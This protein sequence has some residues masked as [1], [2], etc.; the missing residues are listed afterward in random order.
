MHATSNIVLPEKE[1]AWEFNRRKNTEENHRVSHTKV[2]QGTCWQLEK[3]C[4]KLF[5]HNID[6]TL[7]TSIH[8]QTALP[9][10]RSNVMTKSKTMN[11]VLE[12]TSHLLLLWADLSLVSFL[13]SG[14]GCL[15]LWYDGRAT[16][17]AL[18]LYSFICTLKFQNKVRT[19]IRV[20]SFSHWQSGDSH[21]KHMYRSLRSRVT[22]WRFCSVAGLAALWCES[23]SAH[24]FYRSQHTGPHFH[25]PVRD[26]SGNVH[27]RVHILF[28]DELFYSKLWRA[29]SL[30]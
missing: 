24:T 21:Q 26:S 13:H 2:S 20:A 25:L 17:G 27:S 4:R 30:S 1:R 19:D 5:N 7:T 22:V 16:C 29:E 3:E 8:K 18:H 11:Q 6:F 23:V 9:M 15:S 10:K 12:E 14:L 28:P